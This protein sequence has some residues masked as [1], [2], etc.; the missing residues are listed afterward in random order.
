MVRPRLAATEELPAGNFLIASMH[1]PAFDQPRDVQI[2]GRSFGHAAEYVEHRFRG[3]T[4]HARA[5]RVLQHEWQRRDRE[6]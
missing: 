5:P 1:V 3:E 6:V 4:W 2:D